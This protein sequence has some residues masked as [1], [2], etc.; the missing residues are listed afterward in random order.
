M[1]DV[2]PSFESLTHAELITMAH[3]LRQAHAELAPGL[4]HT[5]VLREFDG[6]ERVLLGVEFPSHVRLHCGAELVVHKI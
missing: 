6:F 4:V 3:A 1:P 5:L 2:M